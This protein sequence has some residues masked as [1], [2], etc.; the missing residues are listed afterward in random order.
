MV[1]LSRILAS[2]HVVSN[3]TMSRTEGMNWFKYVPI[4]EHTIKKQTSISY[5][6]FYLNVYLEQ[7]V[8]G[9]RQRQEIHIYIERD[10]THGNYFQYLILLLHFKNKHLI[11]VSSPF[12][13][14][15]QP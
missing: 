10:Q 14:H 5:L 3:E 11:S 15:V 8:L 4:Y 12:C 2:L 7:T 9:T 13:P 1:K 6:L